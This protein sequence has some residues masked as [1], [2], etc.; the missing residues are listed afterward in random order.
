MRGRIGLFG[1]HGFRRTARAVVAL[2]L[3]MLAAWSTT[4]IAT[5]IPSFAF[6][7]DLSTSAEPDWV[8]VAAIEED[9]HL[10]D[11]GA[12]YLAALLLAIEQKGG[13][14]LVVAPDA[15]R[16]GMDQSLKSAVMSS[17]WIFEATVVEAVAGL[18]YGH[19]FGTLLL[20]RSDTQLKRRGGSESADTRPNL[21]SIPS[22]GAIYY[23]FPSV[24]TLY[25]GRRLCAHDVNFP[26]LPRVGDQVLVL[27]PH[28]WPQQA[29]WH[30]LSDNDVVFLDSGVAT[31]EGNSHNAAGSTRPFLKDD[32]DV[33]DKSYREIR[34][35][36]EALLGGRA[37]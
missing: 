5:E 31:D 33:R 15:H 2:T 26:R 24:D 1:A 23:F 10:S 14:C 11:S 37:Q 3:P 17:R 25:R 30:V 20:L 35:L 21:E 19:Q 34:A 9:P 7:P 18:R 16:E 8:S 22:S 32:R 27:T 36:V 6:F 29:D 28:P 13:P 4:A 12:D